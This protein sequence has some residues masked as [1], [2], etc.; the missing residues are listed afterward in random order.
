MAG[1]RRRSHEGQGLDVGMRDQR[2]HRLLVA[3]HHVEHAVRQAG[4][5]QQ[6]G[7][8][9]RGRGIARSE[10]LSTKVLP[11][12]IATGN[13]Q[14][15]TIMG[16][17]NGVMPAPRLAA[18]A[19]SVVDAAADL[20]GVLALEQMGNAAGELHHFDAARDLAP[21][22]GEDLAVFAGDELSQLVLMLVQQRLEVEDAGALSG[23]V[24][25]QAGKAAL[26]ALTASATSSLGRPA[27]SR[28]RLRRWRD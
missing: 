26:A 4:L 9:Q 21:G 19:C 24:S 13:I 10:G 6:F 16:K 25:A 17:L 28:T 12:A 15:G 20:V 8:A 3:M 5:A 11:Q 14:H 23:G 1:D 2:V 22:V 7:Q 18:G 27:E